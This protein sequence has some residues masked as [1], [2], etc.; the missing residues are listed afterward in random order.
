MRATRTPISRLA[1]LRADNTHLSLCIAPARNTVNESRRGLEEAV[2][3]VGTAAP[4]VFDAHLP[5]L[6]Y[7]GTETPAEVYPRLQ[8]AQR[9][10]PVALGPYGPEVLSHHLVRS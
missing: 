1:G 10:A 7:E 3:T 8:A 9:Q 5:T 4:S 2:M 6:P